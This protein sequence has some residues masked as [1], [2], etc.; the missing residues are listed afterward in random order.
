MSKTYSADQERKVKEEHDTQSFHTKITSYPGTKLHYANMPPKDINDVFGL[1]NEKLQKC[2]TPHSIKSLVN[3]T[4]L[5]FLGV[6]ESDDPS[7][8]GIWTD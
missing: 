4:I 6:D 3:S 5:S 8:L 2:L 1:F 7:Y